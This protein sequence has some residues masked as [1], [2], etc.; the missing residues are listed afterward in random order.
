MFDWGPFLAMGMTPKLGTLKGK[1]VIWLPFPYDARL[2]QL[3]R[4]HYGTQWNQVK[5]CWYVIDN[6]QHRLELNIPL[7]SIGKNAVLHIHPIN[8][9]A[10]TQLLDTLRLKGY[11]PNTL[12]TY[13][14]EFAQ[15]LHALRSHSVGEMD[16]ERL[17]SYFLYCHT[18]LKLTANQIHSRI[19]AIKFYFEQ[20]LHREKIFFDIPR[21]KKPQLLP[22]V[23]ST[24]E[25]EHIFNN[26]LN[27]KHKLILQLA[28][29]MGLRVSEIA[30]LKISDIDTKRMIVHL[31]ATKG[32]KDRIVNLPKSVL[33]Q[34]RTYYHK[35]QPKDYLFK[36]QYG[37]AY[38]I[39]SIQ[40]VFKQALKRAGINR[41]I[42]IHSLRH[43]YATHLLEY[44]TD[45]T[46]IQK[47][48]G[49]NDIKTTR[50]YLSVSK[51]ELEKVISPLDK[52]KEKD[53]SKEFNKNE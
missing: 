17:R 36:G 21:P 52:L 27:L 39:R 28:Y 53:S 4:S 48:L 41:P 26:T 6:N 50:I 46:L 34:L 3:I 32:K 2:L 9:T 5:K 42:G 11:S 38:S 33:P 47:L 22:K 23:M 12:K 30:A 20:V 31:K 16:A 44:G 15:L 40:A 8:K 13:A 24:Q 25:L 29:G 19:N 49:H 35:Y 14:N 1:G 37:G 18:Q 10:Y 43:S 51:K 45:V 7:Q